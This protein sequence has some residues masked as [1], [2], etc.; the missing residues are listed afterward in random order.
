MPRVTLCIPTWQAGDFID[1]T[2]CD[3]RAQ[4]HEDLQILISVDKCTDNTAAI[5][6]RHAEEDTRVS[7]FHQSEQLGWTHNVNFLL[8]QVTSPYYAI[9]F[10]DDHVEPNWISHL[11]SVLE[12]RPEAAAAFCGVGLAKIESIG[13]THD[14]SVFERLMRRAVGEEKGSPLRAL[15]RWRKTGPRFPDT[16]RLGYHAQNAYLASLFASGPVI[17]T[18]ELLYHRWAGRRGGVTESWKHTRP[19]RLETDLQIVEI[20]ILRTLMNHVAAPDHFRAALYSFKLLLAQQALQ[21]EAANGYR[22][23]RDYHFDWSGP[24]IAAIHTYLNAQYPQFE[25][26]LRALESRVQA[27]IDNRNRAPS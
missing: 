27:L 1:K 18:P 6:Q 7:V 22:L 16:T 13:E 14:G 24:D 12:R 20:A 26:Q 11:L 25:A 21:D 19:G 8:N 2:I 23:L 3:A 15:T 5:C 4:D 9:Y 10:H 17:A